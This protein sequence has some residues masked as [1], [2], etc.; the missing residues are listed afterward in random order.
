[1]S[2]SGTTSTPENMPLERIE[3]FAE[4][5]PSQKKGLRVGVDPLTFPPGLNH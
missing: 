1:M 4:P 3:F 5:P 2:S